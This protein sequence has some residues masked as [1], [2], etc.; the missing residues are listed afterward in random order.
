MLSP[1]NPFVYF[2]SF[3]G[4]SCLILLINLV[5]FI[6]VCRVLCSPRM[7]SGKDD[8]IKKRIDSRKVTAMQIK[9]AF[10]VMVLLGVTWVFGAFAIGEAKLIFQYIFTVCNSLQGFLIFVIRCLSYPEA[11]K[12][13]Y[14][15][16]TTGQ[17]KRYKGTRPTIA[18]HTNSNSLQF[19]TSENG[20]NSVKTMNSDST[21][22]TLVYNNSSSWG[23]ISKSSMKN[24]R[25]NSENGKSYEENG[26]PRHNL[27]DIENLYAKPTKKSGV[28]SKSE[29]DKKQRGFRP[30]INGS[31]PPPVPQHMNFNGKSELERTLK[32]NDLTSDSD[33][34]MIDDVT[35][36]EDNR[37]NTPKKLPG[38]EN[39][40]LK[41]SP[42]KLDDNDNSLIGGH[43]RE[44]DLC[45]VKQSNN[46]IS[47]KPDRQRRMS[48]VSMSSTKSASNLKR[49]TSIIMINKDF[50]DELKAKSQSSPNIF[51]SDEPV[52]RPPKPVFPQCDISSCHTNVIN[53]KLGNKNKF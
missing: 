6:L 43:E 46:I 47:R 44:R 34:G 19:K 33:V 20:H 41:M 14:H 27:E 39:W 37:V 13:W 29:F 18:S 8:M 53:I 10:T 32:I 17:L 3:F 24:S 25:K 16:F 50:G 36:D 9:G 7:T 48:L 12:A 23:R 26:K 38:R 35:S 45:E 51:Q 40:I 15:F 11:R 2:I 22:S 30:N 28:I 21:V 5:V 31:L 4:P 49:H 42:N 52:V 1:N